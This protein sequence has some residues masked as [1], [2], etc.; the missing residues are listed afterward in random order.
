MS[1]GF[2]GAD[3]SKP[4]TVLLADDQDM[5]RAGLRVLLDR[6]PGVTV[7]AEAANGREAVACAL[8]HRP[9]V[10]LM[11]IRMPLLDGIEA[12]RLIRADAA[13]ATEPG[14]AVIVLTTF[15]S[16]EYLFAALSAGAAG[17]LTKDAGPEALREAVRTVAA[18]QSLLA[19]A[20]TTRVVER[21]LAGRTPDPVAAAIVAGLTDRERDVLALVAKGLTNDEIAE[22]LVLSPATTRTYV[23]RLLTKLDARDR[24]ALVLLAHRAGLAS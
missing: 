23:H 17:F 13:G 22:E 1:E 12:T 11:D 7:V 14:P 15:D 10:V 19:P 8:E 18:G 9:R 5:I 6:T 21:A 16:D 4:I 24:V 2:A 3:V 20:V